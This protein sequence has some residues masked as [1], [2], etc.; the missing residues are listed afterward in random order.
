M[1]FILKN[2]IIV[3]QNKKREVIEG[4]ILIEDGKIKKVGNYSE[5]EAKIVIDLNKKI[6][7]PSFINTH[8]HLGETIYKGLIKK[9]KLDDYIKKTEEMWKKVKNKKFVQ[10]STVNYSLLELIKS[11]TSL[12]VAAR[13]WENVK[14]SNLKAFLGYPIMLSDKLSTYLKDFPEKFDKTFEEFNSNNIKVG[15]WLHSLP[16]L[17]EKILE[18]I[19]EKFY[20]YDNIFL[21]IHI[22]E[23][24]DERKKVKEVYGEYPIEVME[25]YKLISSRTLLVHCVHVDENEIQIIKKNNANVSFCPISNVF[26]KNKLPP[27]KKFLEKGIKISLAS[28]GLATGKTCNLLSIANFSYEHYNLDHQKLLDLITIDA[29]KCLGVEKEVGSIEVGKSA[30]FVFFNNKFH[31]F[32]KQSLIKKIISLSPA[33]EDLLVNGKFLMKNKKVF[34]NEKRIISDFKKA[35]EQICIGNI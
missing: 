22:N 28:D 6:V 20:E 21:T 32:S 4:D 25:S 27:I 24:L 17:N 11:G 34:L 29:A 9:M 19:S 18:M 2:G 15:I 23:T 12:F 31:V 10:N 14:K 35:R 1:D 3:T 33:P 16:F 13:N 26:L 30:D 7:L 5:S 8:F